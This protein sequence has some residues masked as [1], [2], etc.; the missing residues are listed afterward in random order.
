M[1]KFILIFLADLEAKVKKA[2]PEEVKVVEVEYAKL[3]KETEPKR[4]AVSGIPSFGAR[5][6]AAV[7]NVANIVRNAYDNSVGYVVAKGQN[8]KTR[9]HFSEDP[10]N[11]EKIVYLMHGL[12]QN[13]GSKRKFAKQLR[14]FRKTLN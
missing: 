8:W 7:K 4:K 1:I 14:S 10:G 12:M 13:E 2:K 9:K 11:E 6:K 5:A 3:K